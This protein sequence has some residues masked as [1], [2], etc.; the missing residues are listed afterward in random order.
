MTVLPPL[1]TVCTLPLKNLKQT[2]LTD[3]LFKRYA[4]IFHGAETNHGFADTEGNNF[5][6]FAIILFEYTVLVGWSSGNTF[7]S[8][9]GGPRFKP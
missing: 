2:I 6:N 8:G 7:V 1:S 5:C 9:T 3:E 4:N